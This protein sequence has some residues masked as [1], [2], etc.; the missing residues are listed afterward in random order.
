MTKLIDLIAFGLISISAYYFYQAYAL[1]SD[2]SHAL[3]FDAIMI[4]AALYVMYRN[5]HDINIVSLIMV[6]LLFKPINM[7]IMFSSSCSHGLAYYSLM[8]LLNAYTMAVIWMRPVIFSNFGPMKKLKTGWRITKADDT[9]TIVLTLMILFD[10]ILLGEQLLRFVWKDITV[11]YDL[12][13]FLQATFAI[14]MIAVFY[15]MAAS[16]KANESSKYRE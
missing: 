2:I 5:R 9:M 11:F 1:S 13:P 7:A 16:S 12:Y 14:A 10:L 3:G 8:I 15:F 6:V 4:V